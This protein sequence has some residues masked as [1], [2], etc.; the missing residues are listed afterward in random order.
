GSYVPQFEAKAAPT[1]ARVQGQL[2]KG[3]IAAGLAAM[4]I[5][6]AVAIWNPWSSPRPA[7]AVALAVLPFANVSEDPA[8]DFFSDGM[9]DEIAAALAKVPNLRIVASS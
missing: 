2:T 1:V 4:A 3:W 7:S 5:I 8:R 9:T 6:I